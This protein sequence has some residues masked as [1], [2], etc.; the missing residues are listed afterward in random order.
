ML[1]PMSLP[2]YRAPLRIPPRAGVGLKPEHAGDIAKKR[3]RRRFL[4]SARRKLH[5]RWRCA[6]RACSPR[7]ATG[8][9]FRCTASAFRSA[10]RVRSAASTLRD[11]SG[12]SRS[13]GPGLFSEHLAW[14][15]HDDVFLNDL[16][17]V[18]YDEK[19]LARVASHI[20]QVQKVLGVR[21]LLE[22]PST[23]VAFESS[24]MG[25]IEFLS[26]VVAR[27]GC[28]LLLDVNNVHVSAAEQRLRSVRLFES[29]SGRGGRRDPSRRPRRGARRR[30]RAAPDRL[31]R[32]SGRRSGV[33]ALRARDRAGRSGA[34]ADRM[35][36]R[37]AGLCGARRRGGA[38]RRRDGKV[39][40]HPLQTKRVREA[41]MQTALQ[42][43]FATSLLQRRQASAAR[44]RRSP[45]S[46]PGEALRGLPQQ[47]RRRAGA[48]A[49]SRF[50]VVKRLVGEEFFRAMAQVFVTE[51]PPRSPVLFR[52]GSTFP[53]FIAGFPARR[54]CPVPGRSCAARA[55]ARPRIPCRR[56]ASAAGGGVFGARRRQIGGNRRAPPPLRRASDLVVSDRLDLAGASGRRRAADFELAS[57]S[58]AGRPPRTRRRSPPASAQ[59]ATHS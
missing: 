39:L 5:G 41:T 29:V 31:A 13:T 32:R 44:P 26:E 17:P 40:P 38:R 12:S 55:C 48:R 28:G 10:A 18:S 23:Y 43:E 11:C 53:D 14:S 25:E 1:R 51:E 7:S 30:R 37:R 54:W 42:A 4:R 24:T 36:Q 9:P 52:Y 33:G 50:P 19:T 34:D 45:R 57:G 46:R 58:R 47:C 56:R 27:T 21:M 22:N 6:A 59:A 3:A 8:F 35:G 2:T 16:L 15:S 49:R 20:D